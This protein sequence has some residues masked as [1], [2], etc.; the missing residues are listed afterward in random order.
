MTL[1]DHGTEQTKKIVC[2]FSYNLVRHEDVGQEV[3][4]VRILCLVLYNKIK[5]PNPRLQ[6]TP[7]IGSTALVR[8][9][10]YNHRTTTYWF[11]RVRVSVIDIY[12]LD[13]H[14]IVSLN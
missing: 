4:F 10:M 13:I 5:R 8:D 14:L 2:G 6:H 1:V 12:D 9:S 7:R 3:I 11:R